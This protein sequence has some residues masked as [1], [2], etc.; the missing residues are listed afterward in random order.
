M[1]GVTGHKLCTYSTVW[2]RIE[3][4]YRLHPYFQLENLV[5]I[6]KTCLYVSKYG[7]TVIKVCRSCSCNVGNM[8][9]YILILVHV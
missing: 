3:F 9:N 4:S 8:V 6:G 2:M 1:L 5:Q 7:T